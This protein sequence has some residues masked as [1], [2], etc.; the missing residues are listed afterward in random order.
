M[1]IHNFGCWSRTN[2]FLQLFLRVL[3]CNKWQHGK[4]SGQNVKDG[5]IYSIHHFLSQTEG[6]TTF[7]GEW[8]FVNR[9]N[10]GA[11]LTFT[12]PRVTIYIMRFKYTSGYSRA[13]SYIFFNRNKIALISFQHVFYC[14]WNIFV[15]SL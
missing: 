15:S 7:F 1:F 6:M 12:R 3:L 4:K 13:V 8:V 10:Y 5:G 11:N 14:Y 2:K 9:K